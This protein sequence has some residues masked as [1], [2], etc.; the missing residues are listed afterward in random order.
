MSK[1][2]KAKLH[3]LYDQAWNQGDQ[4]AIDELYAAD[5]V[6]HNAAPRTP[7]G[8]E[9]VR[10]TIGGFR[11]AV[12]DIQFTL[13]ELIVD[14]DMVANRWSMTGTQQ[15]EFMGT[16]ATGEKM[17]M[18]GLAMVRVANDKIVEIWTA[19]VPANGSSSN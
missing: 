19:M 1:D 14:G 10:R 11:A 9:G 15:G 5:V 18:S 12:P 8:I 4:A 3:R 7:A 13:E 17:T 16:P 2:I 6:I